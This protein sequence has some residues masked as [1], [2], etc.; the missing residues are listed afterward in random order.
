MSL[1]SRLHAVWSAGSPASLRSP[2]RAGH[3]FNATALVEHQVSRAMAASH[4]GSV[5]RANLVPVVT[6]FGAAGA[7][8]VVHSTV[9]ALR[10]CTE[11][12]TKI[13]VRALTINVH[14]RAKQTRVKIQSIIFFKA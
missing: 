7:T 13:L 2:A 9:F 11:R 14:K 8:G 5:A 6:G 10:G 4:T 1:A 12:Q 3:G